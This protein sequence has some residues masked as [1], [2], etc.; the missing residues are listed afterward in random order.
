[1]ARNELREV[2]HDRVQ[3]PAPHFEL[4]S[5]HLDQVV[6]LTVEWFVRHLSVSATPWRAGRVRRS[7]RVAA[8]G[9]SHGWRVKARGNGQ[10]RRVRI[11]EAALELLAREGARGLTHRAVDSELG[12]PA[13]STSYYYSTRATLLLAAAQRLMELDVADIEAISPG[14]EGVAELVERWLSPARRTRSLARLELL[15][16]TARDPAF[17]FMKRSRQG[18]VVRA[19]GGRTTAKART[20][21]TALVA[22]ADG[23]ILHGLVTGDLR[24]GDATR[25][26]EL[27]RRRDKTSKPPKR[28]AAKR[29]K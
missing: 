5:E 16:S 26:L 14:R 18:F 9:R 22:M 27:L 3:F 8:D 23:L 10:D 7:K 6:R 20:S 12:L 24:R 17:R 28:K 25:A 15:L 4:F 21:G 11:A 29:S 13:G 19:S 1:L 2:D